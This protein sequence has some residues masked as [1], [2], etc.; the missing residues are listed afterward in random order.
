MKVPIR[1]D[2]KINARVKTRR[3]GCDE[4]ARRRRETTTT[5]TDDAMAKYY[6]DI[7]KAA[8]G[9]SIGRPTD[10]SKQIDFPIR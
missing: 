3:R 9:A 2:Q 1:S 7:A 8:K 10:R 5:T 4:D 6:G